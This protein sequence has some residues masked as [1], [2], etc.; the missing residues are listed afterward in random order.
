MNK[1]CKRLGHL[2]SKRTRREIRGGRFDHRYEVRKHETSTKSTSLPRRYKKCQSHGR[3]TGGE[4]LYESAGMAY[5]S[6]FAIPYEAMNGYVIPHRS[7]TII[8]TPK[9]DVRISAAVPRNPPN[10]ENPLN[11]V[12]AILKWR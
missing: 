11:H 7:P 2:S 12:S 8:Q 1:K 6:I 9:D 10:M 3:A 5:Q 4:K